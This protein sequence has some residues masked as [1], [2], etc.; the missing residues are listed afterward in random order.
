[1]SFTSIDYNEPDPKTY[2]SVKLSSSF[3]DNKKVFDSGDFVKDWYNRVKDI[4]QDNSEPF[5]T[6]SSSIDH[7]IMDGAP[8]DS[9]RL[10]FDVDE[11]P[12]LCYE[13]NDGIEFFVKKGT[14]PTWL[15]LREL[16]G[17][18]RTTKEVSE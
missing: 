18:K 4:I 12:Y 1:M 14:T 2:K 10:K 7:F 9:C 15:E 11:N 3:T 5:H 8:F 17:D 6:C 16:C 13:S